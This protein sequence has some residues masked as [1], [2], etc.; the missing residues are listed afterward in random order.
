MENT[1]N[2]IWLF[3]GGGMQKL[4]AEKI[5]EAGYKLI[6]TDKDPNCYCS[7]YADEFVKLDTF[8]IE[9]NLKAAQKLKTKYNIK[10]VLT[11]AAD[12]HETVAN[13]AKELHLPGISPEISH[14]CRYKLETRKILTKAGLPQPKFQKVTNL[15]EAKKAAKK[16]G[17]P[18]VIK[19]SNNS[20]SRGFTNIEKLDDLTP[21]I[22]KRAIENGTTGYAIIEELLF[23]IEIKNELAEQS[24]ETLWYNGKMYWLNGTD[25]FFRKSF[26]LFDSL[27]DIDIYSDM[28]WGIELGHIN[29]IIHDYKTTKAIYDFIYKAGLAIG[30]G[31]ERGGHILKAD[32]MLTKKGPYIIELTLRLSGGWDSS[33]TTPSRGADF[34][35]GVIRLALGERLDLNFWLKHFHFKNPN[36]ISSILTWIPKDAKDCMGRKFAEGLG[37]DREESL[38]NAYKNLLAGRFISDLS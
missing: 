4:A 33:K 37:F 21:E 18:V 25:R 26:L 19:A 27:K 9:S 3:A 1:K 5:I 14:N 2:A 32:I 23:P 38:R 28:P 17:L 16:I 6:L 22:F 12:C 30:M 13:V 29:P 34:V 10:A 20:A 35:G 11:A 31:Q 36:L 7:R 8:D 24:M 15:Q